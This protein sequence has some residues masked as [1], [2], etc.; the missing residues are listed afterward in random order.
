MACF[1]FKTHNVDNYASN[2]DFDESGSWRQGH[3]KLQAE[4]I[5]FIYCIDEKK[6]I[7]TAIVE[8]VY[9]N[10]KDDN[11]CYLTRL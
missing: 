4:D 1:L 8:D 2:L 11:G 10:S 3:K 6:F 9:F 7:S 5:V